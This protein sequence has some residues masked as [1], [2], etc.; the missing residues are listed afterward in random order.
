MIHCIKRRADGL[1]FSRS[2]W[3]ERKLEIVTFSD[4]KQAKAFIARLKLADCDVAPYA[5]TEVARA[6]EAGF[7]LP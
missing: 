1:F 7:S 5:E 6:A 4:A 3:T 2:G